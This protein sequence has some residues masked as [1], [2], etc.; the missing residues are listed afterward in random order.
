MSDISQVIKALCADFSTK[1]V[2]EN[3]IAPSLMRSAFAAILDGGASDLETGALMAAA[4]AI[5]SS[6]AGERYAELVLGLHDAIHERMVWLEIDGGTAATVVL[7]NYGEEG[8][9]AS[10]PLLA[11]LLRRLG[12]RVLVHGAIETYGGLFNCGVLREF[13]VLPATT[14]S[15]AQ[16]QL[17]ED[18]IA[19]VPATLFSPG[20]AAMLSLR[21]RLGI[22]TPAHYLANL[23]MPLR[24]GTHPAMHLL[25]VPGWLNASVESENLF[26]ETRVLLLVS[27]ASQAAHDDCRPQIAFRDSE[28]SASW[29]VLFNEER[30]QTKTISSIESVP[31]SGDPRAWAAWTKKQLAGKSALPAPIVNLLASCLFACGYA[32][33]LNQGKAIAAVETNGL[34]AA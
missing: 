3:S 25:Q 20:L 15:Q 27:S 14:R 34:A 22:S 13:G 32:S 21:N 29:Q 9:A 10:M 19:M 1:A 6:R 30:T 12:I 7:P 24:E 2:D 18:G 8:R 33:D 16:K 4:A 23:L 17:I 26:Q 31:V 11:L 5:E 28:P